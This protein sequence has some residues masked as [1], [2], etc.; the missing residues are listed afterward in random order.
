LSKQ[1]KPQLYRAYE[2]NI[3]VTDGVFTNFA[4]VSIKVQNSNV[5]SPR[6]EQSIYVA[7][8]PE[9]YGEGMLVTQV[10]AVDND[11]GNYGMISYSIPS[12]EMLQYFRVDADS[13]MWSIYLY[14]KLE[15]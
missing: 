8:F 3:S 10:S 14:N 12:E 2:L 1:R 9:N 5:H 4:R 15:I 13:G 11:A 7:E 6:F